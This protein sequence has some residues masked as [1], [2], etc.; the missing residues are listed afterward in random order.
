MTGTAVDLQQALALRLAR[1]REQIAESARRAGRRPEEVTLVGVSKTV[2]R[3]EVDAAYAAGLRDFGENRVQDARAKFSENVPADLRLHL[4]GTLQTN[5]VRHIADLACLIHSV[6]RSALI[7]ELEA[8][9]GQAGRVLPVLIQVNVAGEAQK[10][11]CEPQELPELTERVL[12]CS[13]LELR[14]YMTMAPLVAT[15]EQARPIFSALRD[16]RDQMQARYP[17]ARLADLSMGMTNDYPAAIE[18]GA[19]IVRVGRAIFAEQRP[20]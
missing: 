2:G 16:L 7:T 5:K 10:H 19:T 17:E 3:A 8:R 12:G 15:Q 18:E 14:G 6:D 11:G 4:I 20:A 9:A 1:V 13:H